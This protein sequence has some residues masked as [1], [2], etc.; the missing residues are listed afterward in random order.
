MERVTETKCV[1]ETE[2]MI[3][4]FVLLIWDRKANEIKDTKFPCSV[5][6][7][8]DRNRTRYVFLGFEE[9][10][11]KNLKIKPGSDGK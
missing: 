3:M 1:A 9:T 8:H 6:Q 5:F 7:I 2:G 10:A 4:E 11:T